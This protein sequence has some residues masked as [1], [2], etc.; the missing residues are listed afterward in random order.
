MSYLY[1]LLLIE[2][3]R[4]G[5]ALDHLRR[6]VSLEPGSALYRFRL[7]ETLHLLGEDCREHLA[8]ARSLAPRD[9]WIN[10]LQGQLLLADGRVQEAVEAFRTGL[11]GQPDER[12]IAANLA[13]A[14]SRAGCAD[15]AR[16]VLEEALGR[17]PGDS[18]L[19]NQ[20]GNLAAAAR[21]FAA[22]LEHYEKALQADPMNVEV[23]K[24][25]AAVCIET[26]MILRAEE[27]L[28]WLTEQS[29]TPDVYNLMAHLALVQGELRRAELSLQAGLELDPRSSELRVNLARLR[30]A[31]GDVDQARAIIGELLRGEPG[32][33]RALRLRERIRSRWEIELR[34]AGC[35]RSWWLP[36]E[37][38]AQPPLRLRGEPPPECPAGRCTACGNLYCVGCASKTAVDGRMRCASCGGPLKLDDDH[39]RFLVRSY[40]P[41]AEI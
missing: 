30:L 31:Q 40:V 27:L 35:G 28:G 10:N 26:D 11:Q 38:P 29:P 3:G 14:L 32:N 20:R 34:C 19:H 39:L 33:E 21:D 22:A 6:A 13:E 17:H 25:L 16:G 2:R 18:R 7:A 5:E 9:P 23:A 41:D 24:N 12:D 36:K 15:E 4:R 8:E 37:V 1:A